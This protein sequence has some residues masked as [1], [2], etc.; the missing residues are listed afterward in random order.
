M[1]D[2]RRTAA[3]TKHLKLRRALAATVAVI[4]GSAGLIVGMGSPAA[5]DHAGEP[6]I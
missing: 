3:A 5:A 1:Q 2:T 4:A 6:M